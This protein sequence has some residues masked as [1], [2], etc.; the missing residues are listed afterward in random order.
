MVNHPNRSKRDTSLTFLKE[1]RAQLKHAAGVFSGLY[2]L[3]AWDYVSVGGSMITVGDLR[4]VVLAF[5]TIEQEIKRREGKTV[6][7]A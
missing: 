2:R 7:G 1:R 3:A 6:D 4:E 5:K